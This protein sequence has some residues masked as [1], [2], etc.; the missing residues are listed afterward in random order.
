M[1]QTE[2]A[3]LKKQIIYLLNENKIWV[4]D[5][6]YGAPFFFAKKNNRRLRLFVDY[7]ALNKN[8]IS[9]SYPL[10]C[11]EELLSWLKGAQHFSRLDLRDGY[12]HVPI[13]REDVHKTVYSYRYGIFEYF[14]MPFGLTNAPSIF[15][16]GHKSRSC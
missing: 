10:L 2:L 12:F 11:I 5:S 15:L 14:V 4:S 9:D 7:C 1:D 3:E 6:P 16:E 13:T 8:M